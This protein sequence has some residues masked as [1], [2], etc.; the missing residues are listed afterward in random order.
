MTIPKDDV[1]IDQELAGF[2]AESQ[3]PYARFQQSREQL[4]AARVVAR[5]LE[6]K[7]SRAAELETQLVKSKEEL[8]LVDAGWV[9]PEARKLVRV[10]YADLPEKDR[11]PLADFA[12]QVR[13]PA[14]APRGLKNFLDAPATVAAANVGAAAGASAAAGAAAAATGVGAQGRKDGDRSVVNATGPAGGGGGDPEAA[15][16]AIKIQ[17]QRSGDWTPYEAWLKANGRRGP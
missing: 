9:D 7:A 6:T 8:A 5:D 17:C 14:K 16:R 1:D 11:P 15:L 2:T 10:Y 13:D 12:S 4:R 3:I